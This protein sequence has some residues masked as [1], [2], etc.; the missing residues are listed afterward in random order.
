[1]RIKKLKKTPFH[2]GMYFC[3]GKNTQLM[4]VVEEIVELREAIEEN[5]IEH[6]TEEL[7]DVEIVLPYVSIIT[8]CSKILSIDGGFNLEQHKL[9]SLMLENAL[10]LRHTSHYRYL[11]NMIDMITMAY[12]NSLCSVYESFNISENKVELWKHEKYRRT[13]KRTLKGLVGKDED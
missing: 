7:C 10:R 4:K 13:I 12:A 11:N 1:M 8:F 5:D 9:L 2:Y 3:Q 6:I